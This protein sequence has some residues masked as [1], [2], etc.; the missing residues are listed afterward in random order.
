ML[1][2]MQHRLQKFVSQFFPVARKPFHQATISA[3][4]AGQLFCCKIDISI[5]ASRGAVIE[6]MCQGNIGLNPFK[7][8]SLQRQCL[9][10]WRP[11]GQRMN[12]RTN[13]VDKS[14]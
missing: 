13:V 6:W 4:I 14:W 9:K 7:T 1:W 3:R 5:Q 12:C 8:E 10:K 11:G 2:P